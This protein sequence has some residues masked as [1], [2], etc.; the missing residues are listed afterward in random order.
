[1]S[2]DR[3]KNYDDD[4]RWLVLGFEEMDR[5]GK[6]QYYD[7]EQL[8]TIIDFYSETSNGEMFEKAVRHGERLF[9][10]S[11]DIKLR[12]AHLLCYNEH[13]EE[14]LRLLKKLELVEPDNT[15]VTYALGVAYGAVGQSRKAIQYYL[16]TASDGYKLEIIYDNIGDEYSKMGLFA[17]ART[18][19]QK[20]L[21]EDPE[22][23]HA[24]YELAN[25]YE[26]E[27][28][29]DKWIGFFSRFV[30]DN[31][32]S[33]TAWFCLGEGY[34]ANGEYLQAI[35]AYQYASAIDDKFCDAHM[36]TAS[37]Y[38]MLE[39]YDDAVS[40]LHEALKCSNDKANIYFLL[41]DVFR[42]KNNMVTSNIYF[43]KAVKEDPFYAEAY[44]ALSLNYS[45]MRDYGEAI[46]SCKEALRIN[47]ESPLY[48][49]TLALI[50]S[51]AGDYESAEKFFECAIPYYDDFE[52]GWLAYA[53]YLIMQGKYDEAI[54]ALSK[55]LTNSEA[56]TEFYKRL[57]KCYYYTN[58]YNMLY[59]TVRACAYNNPEGA[60]ELLE[61]CPE[62]NKVPEVMSV[63][64]SE[65]IE[66]KNLKH[67]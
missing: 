8:E 2:T 63:I 38:V 21:M 23:E 51:D 28:L 42:H 43:D 62:L 6:T 4:V 40:S 35:D 19:Y 52:Y 9:P 45:A 32:Y 17:D 15:D 31:P 12:R 60:I 33:K 14:A 25:C 53:D 29:Y 10:Q 56:S 41:G 65:F 61:Y 13:Y 16:K 66:Y 58:R 57:S 36:Q 24:L 27:M 55:G 34:F 11:N 1:M 5:H 49:T 54:D 39:R 48:L 3:F 37:C 50:Y 46:N 59:N 47:P 44:H 22:D 67:K 18:Y 30:K 20:A 26:D 7:V 64:S